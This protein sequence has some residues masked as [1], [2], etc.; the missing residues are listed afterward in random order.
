MVAV[1]DERTLR[2][3]AEQALSIQGA[4]NLCGLAQSFAG[5][6]ARLMTLHE[7]A[8][9]ATVNEHPITIVWLDKLTGLA[10]IQSV[11][12]WRVTRSFAEVAMLAKPEALTVEPLADTEPGPEAS[13]LSFDEALTLW[14]SRSQAR[15]S[16][17]HRKQWPD[18]PNEPPQLSQDPNGIKFVRIVSTDGP[19]R[20]ALA[21][22]EKATGDIFKPDGWKKPAKGVR[23]N[24]YRDA[25]GISS[26]GDLYA[27]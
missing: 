23:G 26:S 13:E 15:M 16:E 21:F 4:V 10:G 12:A 17:R 2:E 20:S 22:V 27:R 7:N 8:A 3:L 11:G 14:V 19:S 9:T 6:M 18:S 5:V 24:I 25:R 1:K